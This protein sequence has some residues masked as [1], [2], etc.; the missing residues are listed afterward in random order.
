[1]QDFS[2][3]ALTVLF[4]ACSWLLVLLSDALMGGE[5]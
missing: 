3:L 2:I 4:A 1:M 5:K